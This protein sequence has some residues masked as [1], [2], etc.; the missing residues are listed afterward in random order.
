LKPE[1]RATMRPS[2]Q[3]DAMAE[4]PIFVGGPSL[5]KQKVE[6]F[7]GNVNSTQWLVTALHPDH[8]WQKSRS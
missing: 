6:I 3:Q 2:F 8:S 7:C 5:P 4:P 1:Q